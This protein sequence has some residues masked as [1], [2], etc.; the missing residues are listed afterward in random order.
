MII[1]V[2]VNLLN[3]YLSLYSV[4]EILD[5]VFIR[6]YKIQ[7]HM[8]LLESFHSMLSRMNVELRWLEQRNYHITSIG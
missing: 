3:F 8:L 4:M 5:P 6:N 1:I 2:V 7:I